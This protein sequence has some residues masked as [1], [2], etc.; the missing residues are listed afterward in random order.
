MAHTPPRGR[1]CSR[2]SSA[3]IRLCVPVR[4][5]TSVLIQY[6]TGSSSEWVAC[7][8]AAF[9]GGVRRSRRPSA[10][11]GAAGRPGWVAGWSEK[12]LALTVGWLTVH[13]HSLTNNTVPK[14]RVPS[15]N[16]CP[17]RSCM[18][19]DLPHMFADS[20]RPRLLPHFLVP[21]SPELWAGTL[22]AC[23]LQ[24]GLIWSAALS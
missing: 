22:E 6:L 4:V 12:G 24:M 14:W 23:L 10:T 2:R 15:A 16:K 13:R 20:G 3:H 21:Q 7:V 11:T 18:R 1:R 17:R 5:R 8:S 19:R 9:I